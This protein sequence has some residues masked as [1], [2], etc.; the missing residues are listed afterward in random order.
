MTMV[1]DARRIMQDPRQFW[2]QRYAEA[3]YAYGTAANDFLIEQ[4]Q[5][6]P[7]GDALC[8]AEGQGRNAIHLAALGHRVS[9]QD[10]SPVGLQRAQELARQRG[11]TIQTICCDLN[12]FHPQPAN[13]D[14]VV[15][16]WMHLPPNL[17]AVVHQRAL[18]ALRPG[19]RLILE[20]YT[21]RQLELNTGGPPQR[22][23]LIEL[24]QLRQEL[25]GLE[26]LVLQERQRPIHEGP[27]HQGPSAVLQAHGRKPAQPPIH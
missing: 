20:A 22:E 10:L 7:P 17:R 15:A 4:A 18:Q 5:E 9:A 13:T 2:D 16:I 14:L 3:A 21:P 12:D 26:W 6:L 23:L 24:D 25:Q 27:Y 8:L 19:G 1:Y 11:V